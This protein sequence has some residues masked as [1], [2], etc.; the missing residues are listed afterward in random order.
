MNGITTD[1]LVIGS[2]LTG[3]CAAIACRENNLDVL[4]CSKASPGLGNCSVVSRA[5]FRSSGKALSVQEHKKATLTAGHALNDIKKVDIMV[6]SAESAL[7]KL[8][9]YG[10]NL[11]DRANGFYVV[12]Q[13]F[14]K[15]GMSLMQPMVGYARSLGI[16]FLSPF[17][18]WE[19]IEL[20]GGA[21]GVWGFLY[22]QKEPL[23]I[24]AKAVILAAGGAGALYART[25]NPPGIT[26]DGYALA[27]RAG[28]PL[29]D[30]EFVQFYPLGT[31]EEGKP[32]RFLPHIA[33]EV[34]DLLNAAGE[35]IVDKYAIEKRP[36]A[37]ASRDSLSRAMALEVYHGRGVKQAIKLDLSAYEKRW[38][39]E[40]GP[41]NDPL[42]KWFAGFLAGE[43][44]LPVMPV[45]HFCMGGVVTDGACQTGLPGLFAAGEVVGGL[46]GANRLGGNALSETVVFGTIAGQR[47]AEFARAGKEEG[48]DEVKTWVEGKFKK[49]VHHDFTGAPGLLDGSQV[50]RKIRNVMWEHVGLIKSEDSLQQAKKEL[51]PYQ[52]IKHSQVKT[53]SMAAFLELR[54][55]LL[56]AEMIVRASLCRQ[57]SRGSHYRLDYPEARD[58]WVKHIQ[59]QRADERMKITLQPKE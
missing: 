44:S 30:M 57:E 59:V 21:K 26:G 13:G 28:L 48:N 51:S 54:N 5:A 20:D 58:G 39:K 34:G 36:L 47:A 35:N 14:G 46:H 16:K 25:D 56:V 2:G 10:V 22:G 41:Q 17:F 42:R 50:K 24:S 53:Q 4:V 18:S 23:A 52:G 55:M 27:Y 9:T 45:S 38:A 11:K 12:A 43:R 8:N 7:G 31:A 49:M 40:A 37:I 33:A 29:L 32:G 3:L 15:E 19:I 6:K 1:V